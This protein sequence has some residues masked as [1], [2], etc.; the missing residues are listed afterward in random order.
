ME[1]LYGPVVKAGLL[2]KL[3]LYKFMCLGMMTTK[4]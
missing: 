2:F 4:V 3:L 1:A